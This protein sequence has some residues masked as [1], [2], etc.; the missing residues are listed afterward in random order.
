MI[1]NKDAKIYIREKIISSTS[2]IGK[3]GRPHVEFG[4]WMLVSCP[5]QEL[6]QNG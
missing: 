2:G 5:A 3:A 6:I 4:S 1:F